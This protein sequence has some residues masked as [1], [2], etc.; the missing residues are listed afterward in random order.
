MSLERACEIFKP[1]LDD[2]GNLNEIKKK[3]V[4]LVKEDKNVNYYS[5][6][7]SPTLA[8]SCLSLAT[9]IDIEIQKIAKYLDI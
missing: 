6:S 3:L 2:Y 9:K 1:I 4:S 5:A 7:N 8:Q